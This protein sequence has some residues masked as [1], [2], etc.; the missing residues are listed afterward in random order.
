MDT[1][2]N[3]KSD[4]GVVLV[5][6]GSRL[7]YGKDVLIQLAQIYNENTN[8]HVEIGFMNMDKPSI[9]T[10]INKLADMGVKKIVVTPVFLADGVHTTQDIPRILGLDNGNESQE[11][12]H[13]H[14][15]H[16]HH[17][18]EEEEHIHFHGEIIYTKPLGADRR[19][20][21]IIKDRVDNAL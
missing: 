12:N 2:S 10:S 1:N 21:D 9:P 4:V 18:E 3:L 16:H 6:H 20:A 14:H 5:G 13:H 17:H 15:H 8:H 19:I 7:P 11:H